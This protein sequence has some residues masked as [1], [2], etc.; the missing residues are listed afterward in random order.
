MDNKVLRKKIISSFFVALFLTLC[1]C[2]GVPLIVIFAGKN[3]VVM[4]I[5]IVCTVVGFYGTPMGWISFGNAK[6]LERV[7]LAV[8]AE[9]LLTVKDI[10]AQLGKTEAQVK[11]SLTVCFQKG[12]L[13]GYV[14]DGETISYNANRH[15]TEKVMSWVCPNCGATNTYLLTDGVVKCPYCGSVKK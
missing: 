13:F 12:Y 1:L 7:V 11:E 8:T 10:A 3:T 4:I 2:C 5:G 14:F 9:N 15:P 6:S